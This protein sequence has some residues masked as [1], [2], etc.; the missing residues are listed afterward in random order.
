M[1]SL[2]CANASSLPVWLTALDGN[3]SDQ[4][5]FPELVEAYLQQLGEDEESPLMVAD[6]ALYNQHDLPT[7]SEVA[8]WVTRVPGTLS[9]V[10]ELYTA[11]P[12]DEMRVI[13]DETRCMEVDSEYGGVKQRWLLVLHEP[14][15]QR[16]QATLDRRI[17]KERA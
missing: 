2:I 16:Q 14:S 12:V 5:H 4:K 11:I 15:R 17:A 1:L 7:L 10:R 9:A 3:Q 8:L 13:D 6:S